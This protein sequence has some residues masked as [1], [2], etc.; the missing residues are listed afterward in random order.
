LRLRLLRRGDAIYERRGLLAV[1]VAPT[2]MA[3]ISGMRFARFMPANA[4]ATLAWA[5]LIGLGAYF[6][7]PSVADW[8]ADAGTLGLIAIG[9]AVVLTLAGRWA[10]TRARR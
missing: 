2:W 1:Y 6:A 4:I 8:L 7:G 3:G 10:W 5:L 9:L